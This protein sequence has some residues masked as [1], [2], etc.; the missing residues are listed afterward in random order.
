ML[1]D[2]KR[3]AAPAPQPRNALLPE[4]RQAPR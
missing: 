1:H 3:L 4:F 2:V